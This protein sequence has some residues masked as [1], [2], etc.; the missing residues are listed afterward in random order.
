[1]RN[2]VLI[3][4]ML[5][6]SVV[7]YASDSDYVMRCH[8]DSLT[9]Y[10]LH[11]QARSANLDGVMAIKLI[12]GSI[13]GVVVN[14]FGIKAFAF[15]V[16]P[17]RKEV[18]LQDVMPMLNHWYIKRVLKNDLKL[19]FNATN[20]TLESSN[21]KTLI[22]KLDDGTIKMTN[23]KYKIEY[24]IGEAQVSLSQ[25]IESNEPEIEFEDE[26]AQ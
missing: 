15:S 4:L 6:C 12:D 26:T 14:D 8:T 25:D 5:W 10:R 21:K 16:S 17:N 2:F 9:S 7:A 18:N 22:T 3:S 24:T 1:M 19:L 13:K 20:S 23:H 11:M